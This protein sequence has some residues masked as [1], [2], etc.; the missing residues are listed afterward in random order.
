MENGVI[1]CWADFCCLISRQIERFLLKRV[2]F[3]FFVGYNFR[4][5]AKGF[6]LTPDGYVC[7][8]KILSFLNFKFY[9]S[10][11]CS[12]VARVKEELKTIFLHFRK[13]GIYLI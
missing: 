8:M 9:F 6:S 13:L 2:I 11:F 1:D 10:K 12:T 5:T 7:L 4:Q 3:A